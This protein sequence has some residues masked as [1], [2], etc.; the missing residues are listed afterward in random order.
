MVDPLRVG[1]VGVGHMGNYHVVA[2]SELLDADLAAVCE[3]GRAHV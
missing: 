3:I 1:V 2:L